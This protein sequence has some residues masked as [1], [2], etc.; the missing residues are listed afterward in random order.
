MLFTQNTKEERL[1]ELTGDFIFPEPKPFVNNH[2]HTTFSFSPY[3]P[4]AAVYYAKM[5]GLQSAGIM[6][7]DSIA[8]AEEFIEAG[9]IA[10]LPTTI[11][12]ECRS[13]FSNTGLSGKLI[14]HPDQKSCAYVALHGIPHPSIGKIADFFKPYINERRKRNEA[15]TQLLN[16]KLHPLSVSINYFNEIEPLSEVKNGGTVTERHLLYGVALKLI[17]A[18]GKGKI[19]RDYL[20]EKLEIKA[21]NKIT[22]FLD[23]PKNPHYEYDLLG[24][25]KSDLV[26]A[27]YIDAK[28]ECPKPEELVRLANESGAI[29]AYA[30]LG[31]IC[32]SI[33]GD[34]KAQHFE[35]SYID[36]LFTTI[37]LLGFNAVT[38]MPSRNTIEQ[39]K[40]I[41]KL[42]GTHNLLEISG[43]DINSSRQSFICDALLKPEFTHLN[44]ATWALIGHEKA[45]TKNLG[46]GFFSPQ[47][48]AQ[49][50]SL[51]ERIN[52]F[53]LIGI[54]Q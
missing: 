17:K 7:H 52:H 46:A 13:D 28:G 19:L 20:A 38:Y 48:I 25:L 44:D 42:C 3:S 5:A 23:D 54:N 33:T 36:E 40:R 41:Q 49:F 12:V 15:M 16:K 35:D 45:A 30:Y 11:G 8:G 18:I 27:F 10:K 50:P 43:E 22:A 9:R 1:S 37:K 6:D 21:D 53:K 34:K 39:L 47:I 4:T 26:P 14:N 29:L 51:K 32:S 24:L 31:D 2:I